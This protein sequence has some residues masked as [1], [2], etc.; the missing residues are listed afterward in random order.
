M[1][2]CSRPLL[3]R[4]ATRPRPSSFPSFP[5]CGSIGN[6]NRLSKLGNSH[7]K[8]IL[9]GSDGIGRRIRPNLQTNSQ[10]GAEQGWG[11]GG[12][13]LFLDRRAEARPSDPAFGSRSGRL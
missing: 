3:T 9:E 5:G 11:S 4:E 12:G 13:S 10:T 6:L 8:V 1:I 7:L 2:I